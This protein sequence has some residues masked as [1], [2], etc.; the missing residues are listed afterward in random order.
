MGERRWL[1]RRITTR[2]SRPTR[3]AGANHATYRE[4]LD[5]QYLDD[6]DAWRNKYK[7]P[8]RDLRDT[9]DRIRNWDDERR[10]GDEERDGIV[11]EVIFPNT[12]PPFFPTFVLFAGPAKPEDY[13]HRLAGIRAHN[14]WLVDF[15]G[16]VP[17][18][19]RR[20]RPDLRERRRRRDRR[21][22]VDQG[23]RPAWRHPPAE[24]RPRREVGQPLYD[25]YYDPLWK[26]C[27]DLGC[28]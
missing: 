5:P 14:R 22:E 9:S 17:G 16:R 8:F 20:H 11:G 25:P 12:V 7:N 6:F 26:V 10:M 2:S 15:C 1:L 3:H 24:R 28:R 27:E 21:R 19:T 23:A 18:A 13:E 4:Y